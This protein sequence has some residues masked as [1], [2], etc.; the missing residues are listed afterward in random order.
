MFV[1]KQLEELINLD[2]KEYMIME[3]LVDENVESEAKEVGDY[4]VYAGGLQQIYGVKNLVDAFHETDLPFSLHLYGNGDSIDYI[5]TLTEVDSRIKYKGLVS[6]DELLEIESQAK[7]LVNPRP[8]HGEL[9]TRYNFPSKLM[10]F[11][12]SGRP[13][14]TT[15]L[16]GIPKEYEDYMFF[17][18]DDDKESIKSELQRVLSLEESYLANFGKQAQTYVNENKTN[19]VVA[20]KMFQM[21]NGVEVKDDRTN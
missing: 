6:H 21:I 7:L 4:C 12:Q 13:V 20:K 8:V 16:L 19:V 2:D 11:M 14:L 3:G 15:K 17:F 1:T 5:N 18:E 10:E 9:D